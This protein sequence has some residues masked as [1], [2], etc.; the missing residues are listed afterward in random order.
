MAK[1]LIQLKTALKDKRG[2]TFLLMFFVAFTILIFCL[3]A[4]EILK[5]FNIYFTV[6]TNL[7]RLA[8]NA[9]ERNIDDEYRSDGYNYLNT[10]EATQDFLNDFYWYTSTVQD[11]NDYVSGYGSNIYGCKFGPDGEF[12]YMIKITGISADRY[13]ATMNCT[14]H[15]YIANSIPGLLDKFVFDLKLDITSTNFRID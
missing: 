9:V 11:T 8:N 12:L 5:V 3:T 2:A 7:N 13:A 10:Y 4:F 14:G 15:L 6:E 1:K